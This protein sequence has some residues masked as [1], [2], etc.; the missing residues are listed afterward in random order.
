[1]SQ[2]AY[3]QPTYY[4]PAYRPPL[5][6]AA[7]TGFVLSLLGIGVPG[8]IVSI[9]GLVETRGDAKRG[10]GLAVAGVVLGVIATAWNLVILWAMFSA[11]SGT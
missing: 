9:G 8:L 3:Y 2:P 7:V 10:R 11:T 5:S 6:A 4:T 1:M